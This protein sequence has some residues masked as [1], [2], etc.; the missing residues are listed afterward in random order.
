MDCSRANYDYYLDGE[1]EQSRTPPEYIRGGIDCGLRHGIS[2][3][4]SNREEQMLRDATT[5]K[6]D[7]S[8]DNPTPKR[9]QSGPQGADINLML[10]LHIMLTEHACVFE[11][12][13]G[14][15]PTVITAELRVY[16]THDSPLNGCLIRYSS[17]VGGKILTA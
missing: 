15:A 4:S 16:P 14:L 13:T 3:D 5:Q 9:L 10:S 1:S 2:G 11:S 17:G 7:V 8:S 6:G 12:I